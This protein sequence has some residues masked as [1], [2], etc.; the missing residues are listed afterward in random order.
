MEGIYILSGITVAVVLLGFAIKKLQE[1]NAERVAN[2]EKKLQTLRDD[3]KDAMDAK[4]EKVHAEIIDGLEKIRENST[5]FPS[6]DEITVI[7]N[8]EITKEKPNNFIIDYQ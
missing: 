2:L 8:G 3:T 7:Q 6:S 5:L 1:S 4:R